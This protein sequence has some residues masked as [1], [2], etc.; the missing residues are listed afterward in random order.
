M[1]N[2]ILIFV[3]GQSD[4]MVLAQLLSSRIELADAKG[5][6]LVMVPAGGKR[7]L[8]GKHIEKA[9]KILCNDQ[10]AA[11]IFIPDLYPP[12]VGGDH[13]TRLELH[14]LLSHLLHEEVARKNRG[15]AEMICQRFMPHCFQYDLEVLLLAAEDQLFSYL[16][17]KPDRC[18]N[19]T[20]EEQD[21]DQNPKKI[22]QG[23]FKKRGR[24]YRETKDSP[25]ILKD[26]PVEVLAEKC[27]V[28]FAPFLSCLDNLIGAAG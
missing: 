15:Q 18:W 1:I 6:K 25:A 27:P 14:S 10:T 28:S 19:P 5:I 8:F 7:N 24:T 23:L 9:A 16:E 11:I 22:V 4:A 12:N 3:E 26:V 17:M 21:H 13:R 20:V 2:H